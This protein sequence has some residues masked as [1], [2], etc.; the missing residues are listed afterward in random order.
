[1]LFNPNKKEYEH[2]TIIEERM[3]P[4]KEPNVKDDSPIKEYRIGFRIYC[5]DGEEED[6][7][8]KR[9]NGYGEE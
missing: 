7:D 1:M 9:F 4:S 8:H 2:A 6:K 5:D 3:M